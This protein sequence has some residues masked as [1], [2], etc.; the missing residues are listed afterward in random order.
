MCARA[1]ISH[2]SDGCLLTGAGVA[3]NVKASSTWEAYTL[4]H[5]LAFCLRYPDRYKAPIKFGNLTQT[6]HS[7]LNTTKVEETKNC[8]L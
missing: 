4:R 1:P 8:P 3:D 5:T 2:T 6:D 7:P